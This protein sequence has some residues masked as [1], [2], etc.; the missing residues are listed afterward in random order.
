MDYRVRVEH[1]SWVET[2]PLLRLA[3]AWSVGLRVEALGLAYV[4]LLLHFVVTGLLGQMTGGLDLV[5]GRSGVLPMLGHLL[6][7]VTLF[8]GEAVAWV[9]WACWLLL[10]KTYVGGIL[11]RMAAQRWSKHDEQGLT[12]A[13]RVVT[14]RFGW[15]L[16]TPVLPIGVGVMLLV[17][18]ALAGLMLRVPY[19]EW[20]GVVL[21]AVGFPL[22]VVSG[23]ILFGL[24]L[25]G[26]LLPA[27]LSVEG[28][29]GY[30]ALSRIYAFAVTRPLSWVGAQLVLGVF[31]VLGFCVL[32]FFVMGGVC[33]GQWLVSLVSGLEL[34]LLYSGTGE[35]QAAEVLW[36]WVLLVVCVLPAGVVSYC[37]A[38]YTWIYLT[39]R[40]LY[41][42]TPVYEVAMTTGPGS[43]PNQRS[44]EDSSQPE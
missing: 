18:L 1:V 16:L 40:Q 27:S 19:L 34:E 11:S 36:W 17:P 35:S 25:S 24:V 22:T 6:C 44:D 10:A 43:L 23:L 42:G 41:D 26:P 30:D 39:L 8:Q 9:I 4:T 14:R 29:D 5:M 3:R 38:G 21:A 28:T 37:Y 7:P 20:V 2:M 33:C 15:Y 31:G 32:V 13:V 12:P